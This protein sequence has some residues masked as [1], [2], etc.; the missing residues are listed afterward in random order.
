[1]NEQQTQPAAER[2]YERCLCREAVDRVKQVLSIRSDTAREHLRNSRLEFL[3]A[4]R[5]VV[6]DRIAHLSRSGEQ[7][8]K[9]TIE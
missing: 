3:K 7:G 9:V 4:V 6:D 5:A 2:V 8:T 1:M